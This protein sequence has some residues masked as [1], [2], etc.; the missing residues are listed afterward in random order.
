M[1]GLFLRWS[2]QL[3][4]H[5]R[6]AVAN[7]Q[8]DNG[9]QLAASVSYYAALSF[10]PL[11]LI[12]ISGL[13][14]IFSSTGWGQDAQEQLLDFVSEQASPSLAER[15]AV[16]LNN[17]QAK[18]SL[19]GPLG[20][21]SLLITAVLIF[22]QFENA[23][24]QIW[25]IDRSGKKSIVS[26]AKQIVWHRLRAFFMLLGVGGLVLLTFIAG[27]AITGVSSLGDDLLPLP[28]VFWS[29]VQLIVT[30]ALNWIMFTLIYRILPKVPVP[31]SAAA[32]GGLLASITWEVGRQILAAMV[33][34]NKYSAYGVVGA[35]IAIMLWVYYAMAVIFLCA[36]YV[37]VIC[38]ESE[39]KSRADD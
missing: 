34:G 36:E 8:E 11:L 37:Q 20:L 31:W 10:F 33:I 24:D 27:I 16:T 30:L 21:I 32:Q 12:L 18:A 23:F 5:L 26:K 9:F 25:N 14:Y 19:N 13:G 3:W 7:F 1:I 28:K 22:S 29:A 39:R 35:F 38:S 15:V 6:T 4:S 17:V 2:T